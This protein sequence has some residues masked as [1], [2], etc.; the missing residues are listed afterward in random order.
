M[1]FYSHEGVDGII[2]WGFW[3]REHWCPNAAIANGDNVTPNVAGLAYMN[4]F[5]ETFRL[6]GSDFWFYV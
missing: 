2:M 1:Y 4:L 3:D 6:V 5:Q